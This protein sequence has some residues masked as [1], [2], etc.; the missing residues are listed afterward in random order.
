MRLFLVHF[1]VALSVAG[2]V[3]AK[4]A[5]PRAEAAARFVS[6]RH[7]T[8]HMRAGP[9]TEYPI[10]WTYHRQGL[11]LQVLREY[12]NWRYVRDYAGAEGWIHVAG[13]ARKRTIVVVGGTRLL[14]AEPAEGARPVARLET[15]VVGLLEKCERIWCRVSVKSYSGWI[16]QQE[17]WG[18]RP[19]ERLE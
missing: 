2:L 5:D 15:G 10:R 16:K 17:V 11:P 8:V 12:E 9:G 6:L 13:L 1:L 19:G 4:P 7:D 14:R 18:V 3:V